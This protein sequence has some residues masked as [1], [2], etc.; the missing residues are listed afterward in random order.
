MPARIALGTERRDEQAGGRGREGGERVKGKEG[1]GEEKLNGKVERVAEVE[2]S[3]RRSRKRNTETGKQRES[4]HGGRKRI[5]IARATRRER[6]GE[7]GYIASTIRLRS[8]LPFGT[9]LGT[10]QLGSQ[11]DHISTTAPVGRNKMASTIRLLFHPGGDRS[12][13]ILLP[14]RG[15]KRAPCSPSAVQSANRSESSRHVFPCLLRASL[16]GRNPLWLSL[17]LS[18][19]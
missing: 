12:F 15:S 19:N 18:R 13:F 4:N 10:K 3:E 7:Y 6:R 9:E 2:S 14:L 5:L 17:Q 11:W 16:I 1:G 8:G